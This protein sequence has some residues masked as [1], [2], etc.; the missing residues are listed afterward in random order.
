MVYGCCKPGRVCIPHFFVAQVDPTGNAN[1]V[2]MNLGQSYDLHWL[3][4]TNPYAHPTIQAAVAA[5]Q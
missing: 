4:G 1:D 5:C 3:P 2:F